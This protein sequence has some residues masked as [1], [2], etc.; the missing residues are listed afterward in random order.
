M[1][2]YTNINYLVAKADNN[3]VLSYEVLKRAVFSRVFSCCDRDFVLNLA[4]IWRAYTTSD[5]FCKMQQQISIFFPMYIQSYIVTS[6]DSLK[7]QCNLNGVT[8]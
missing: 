6:I 3:L 5:L 2:S 1:L 8:L 4:E 7:L